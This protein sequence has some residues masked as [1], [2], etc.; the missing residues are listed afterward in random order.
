MPSPVWYLISWF[1]IASV[2]SGCR[3]QSIEG[4][5][6]PSCAMHAGDTVT[7]YD[8]KFE[9]GKFTDEVVVG[10]DGNQI[11]RFPDYPVKGSYAIDGQRLSFESESGIEPEFTHWVQVE[12]QIYLFTASQFEQWQ[13][14]GSIARCALVLQRPASN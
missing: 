5:F 12:R 13:E 11:D 7:L 9:W 10:E 6:L 4:E 2:L 14:S 3:T 1:F 8:N